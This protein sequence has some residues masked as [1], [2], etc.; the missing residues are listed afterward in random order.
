MSE[1]LVVVLDGV[2]AGTLERAG[3]RLRFAYDDA[4]RCAALVQAGASPK[5]YPGRR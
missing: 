1:A 5:A 3:S 4:A 2:V